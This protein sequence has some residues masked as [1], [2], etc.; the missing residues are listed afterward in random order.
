LKSRERVFRALELEESDVI[1]LNEC[2]SSTEAAL[3]FFGEKYFKADFLDQ[4]IFQARILG[5]DVITIPALGF[6][7]GPG[8]VF[9]SLLYEGKDHIIATSPFGTLLYWRKKPYFSKVLYGPV[10]YPEDL[11]NLRKPEVD[12]LIPRVKN[13]ARMVQRAQRLGYFVMVEIK[14]PMESPWM[15]LRNGGLPTF[16]RDIVS[17]STFA[18]KLI[19]AAFEFILEITELIID[20][21]KPDA[22]WMTDDL[23]DNKGP[24]MNPRIYR[25]LINPWH[26]EITKRVHGKGCKLC[27][28]SHGNINLIL[29][30]IVNSGFD[31]IDPLDEADGMD[32]AAVK[33]QYGD[34]ICL[35][36]GI[37]KNIGF[38]E[39][40]DI[41]KHVIEA[42]RMGGF[43]G[44]IMM[45][46]GGIP[47]E[48]SL[49]KLNCYLEAVDKA[50]SRKTT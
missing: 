10:S 26:R 1:P 30:D 50:R 43:T 27:L 17:N 38:M 37:T 23:G 7:G 18:S 28:H 49:G 15:Y 11:N 4:L 47:A 45:S 12:S 25:T 22:I 34:K 21:A 8:V 40:E 14:G 24:F 46:A 6:P 3:V 42:A 44:Y 32:L 31:S 33:D 9:E 39:D 5:S 13:L 29:K 48:M 20:I 19:K 35:M 36:G 41:Q 16:L 2:F